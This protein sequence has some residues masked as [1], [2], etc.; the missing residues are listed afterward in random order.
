MIESYVFD[1]ILITLAIVILLHLYY[2]NSLFV[3]A[4]ED[5][6]EHMSIFGSSNNTQNQTNNI[7]V[8][9]DE[10]RDP[11]TKGIER[12]DSTKPWYSEVNRSVSKSDKNYKLIFDD[13]YEGKM[14]SDPIEA[15]SG[16]EYKTPATFDLNAFTK[17][18]DEKFV[19][20]NGNLCTLNESSENMKRYIRDYVL[21]GN[22]Q[23]GCAID[24]SQSDFTRDEIEAYR[25]THLEF[26]DK[27]NGTSA[28][29]EDPV[30]RMNVVTM[31]GGIKARGQT[32]AD[33]YDNVV[34]TRVSNLN[35]PGF[36]M[37]TSIPKT[38]CVAP[39]TI[40]ATSGVPQGYYTGDANAG[41]KFFM[42]DNWMY[43]NE[44]PNN[45]GFM[46]DNIRAEDPLMEFNRML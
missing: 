1:I 11:G 20:A 32:I 41:G 37:G 13:I 36:I 21:D 7:Q 9:S 46:F 24:K 22:A 38:K 17:N 26:R 23:C 19:D 12:T 39:P 31:H 6:T 2:N 33:Y 27:I 15:S 35:G 10:Y 5:K 28:P 45:G 30:D 29:V 14:T 8:D 42:R 44:N 4:C 3:S 40:D 43:N 16:G 34:D 25:E 18:T